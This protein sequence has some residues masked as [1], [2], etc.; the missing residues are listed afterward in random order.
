MS[1]YRLTRLK[2]YK[3]GLQEL[4]LFNVVKKWVTI[5]SLVFVIDFVFGAFSYAVI[6]CIF[7]TGTDGDAVVKVLL[8]L[9][10]IIISIFSAL[11][12]KDIFNKRE[13]IKK[14]ISSINKEI[15]EE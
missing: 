3:E 8:F 10:A 9:I 11:H 12:L 14:C 2:E 4:S 7:N 6:K 15:A 13:H 1:D 5:I